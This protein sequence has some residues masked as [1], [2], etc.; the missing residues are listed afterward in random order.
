M[1]TFTESIEAAV[2][3]EFADREWSSYMVRQF[4]EGQS[5]LAAEVGDEFEDGTV[6]FEPSG[7]STKVTVEV[8]VEP[9]PGTDPESE[10]SRAREGVESVLEGYRTFV[11]RRCEETHCR[12]R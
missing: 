10:Y 9:A 11:L 2:P 7:V 3:L 12:N 8:A 4:Y 5:R 6:T 1:R